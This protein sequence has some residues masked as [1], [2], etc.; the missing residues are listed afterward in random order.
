MA[1]FGGSAQEAK[2]KFGGTVDKQGAVQE[3]HYEER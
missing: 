1:L 3:D 2:F